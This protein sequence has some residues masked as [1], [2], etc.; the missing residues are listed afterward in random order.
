VQ[1]ALSHSVIKTIFAITTLCLL[2]C[3]SFQSSAATGAVLYGPKTVQVPWSGK[4]ASTA[5]FQAASGSSGFIVIKNGDGRDLSVKECPGRGREKLACELG[6]VELRLLAYLQRPKSIEIQLNGVVIVTSEMLPQTLGALTV[7]VKLSAQNTIQLSAKGFPESN[8]TLT[9]LGQPIHV[10]LPPVASF[11]FSPDHEIAPATVTFTGLSSHDPDGTIQSYNWDFGD[12]T[13]LNGPLAIHLYAAAGVYNVKL[14][15]TDDLGAT[16]STLQPV[17]VL[18]NQPPVSSFTAA[19][20]TSDGALKLLLDGSAS[21]DPDGS[22]ATYT[23]DFG[24]GSTAQG[25]AVQHI[26]AAPGTYSVSLTVLDNKGSSG[27]STQPLAVVDHTAPVITISAPL[28]G[29]IVTSQSLQVS[30]SS[31]KN[32]ASIVVSLGNA[33]SV[34]LQLTGITFS[35]SVQATANGP[36][37][38]TFTATDLAGNTQSVHVPV[39]F[40]YQIIPTLKV[41]MFNAQQ[42][43]APFMTAFST[44]G[45]SATDNAAL[46]FTYD[47]GDGT[48]LKTQSLTQSHTYVNSGSFQVIVKALHPSGGYASQSLM[49]AVTSLSLPVH[50]ETIAPPLGQSMPTSMVDQVSFIYSGSNPIQTGADVTT[51]DPLRIAVLKGAVKDETGSPLPGVQIS[52]GGHTEFGSTLSRDDGQFDLVVNGGGQ[53][54]LNY[55]RSGYFSVSRTIEP[56]LADYLVTAD[57]LMSRP[58]SAVSVVDVTGSGAYQFI[59]SSPVTDSRGTRT[60]RLL[61][62]S[63]TQAKLQAKDGSLSSV[64]QLSVRGTEYTVGDTGPQRMP[65]TLPQTSAYTYA[66]ELSADEAIAAGASHVLFSKPVFLYTDNFLNFP[67]GAGVPLGSLDETRGLWVPETDGVI[68]KV[69]SVTGGQAVLSASKDESQITPAQLSLLAI[70]NEELTAIG[71]NYTAGQSFW[72][73]SLNHFTAVDLN[74]F[75]HSVDGVQTPLNLVINNDNKCAIKGQKTTACI[76]D[77]V[78][79]SLS[80]K[81]AVPGA[82]FDLIYDSARLPGGITGRSVTIPVLNKG[83][84]YGITAS[85]AEISIAGRVLSTDI[86]VGTT[87]VDFIWD[88]KDIYG[89]YVN[90]IVPAV[91]LTSVTFSFDYVVGMTPV[92]RTFA[93]PNSTSS[94][95]IT[96]TGN[97]VNAVFTKTARIWLGH[98]STSIAED[99]NGWMISTHHRFDPSS[100]TVYKGD[101]TTIRSSGFAKLLLPFAGTAQVAGYGGDGGSALLA[102]FSTPTGLALGN[103]NSVYVVDLENNRIRKIAPDGTVSNFAGNGIR[104]SSGDGGTATSASVNAPGRPGFGLDG[105]LYFGE[106][107]GNRIRKVCNGIISTVAGTGVAG[108]SGDGG[109]ATQAQFNQPRGVVIG[110]DGALYIDDSG[111]NRVRKIDAGGIISTFAGNGTAGYS[112]D[113]G[114][115]IAAQLSNP[116]VTSLDSNGNVYVADTG[117][118]AIRRIDTSGIITTVAGTG[119]KGNDGDGLLATVA[120]LDS[121]SCVDVD[122]KGQLFIADG[123]A[124]VVRRVSVDGVISTLSGLGKAGFAA[125]NSYASVTPLNDPRNVLILRNGDLLVSEG[126]NQTVRIITSGYGAGVAG[127]QV[128]APDG[129]EVYQFDLQG[130]HTKTLFGR[131][132]QT[133]VSFTYNGDNVV[134]VT[135]ANGLVTTINRDGS[136]IAKS[137]VTPFGDQ[138]LLVA[139]TNGYLSSFTTATGETTQMQN[140]AR[141]LM[142][143]FTKPK[144]NAT[145][146]TF[147]PGGSIYSAKESNG[148]ISYYFR[149]NTD[150]GGVSSAV[151]A[152]GIYSTVYSAVDYDTLN[153]ASYEGGTFSSS[154]EASGNFTKTKD[155]AGVTTTSTAKTDDRFNGFAT[156]SAKGQSFFRG[157]LR[158]SQNTNTYTGLVS[159][160]PFTFTEKMD[161]VSGDSHFST[162]YSSATKQFKTITPLGRTTIAQIDGQE[163]LIQSRLGAF[164]AE[165]ISYNSIG[166]IAQVTVGDRV[167]RFQYNADGKLLSVTNALG[168]TTQFSIDP[169]GKIRTVASA[170]GDLTKFDYD[171]NSNLNQITPPGKLAHQMIFDLVDL[172]ASYAPPLLGGLPTSTTYTYDA[173]KF[174]L[175]AVRPDGDQIAIVRDKTSGLVTSVTGKTKAASYYYNAAKQISLARTGDGITTS[176]SY[177][178]SLLADSSVSGLVTTQVSYGYTPT[179]LLSSIVVQGQSVPLT[180]NSDEELLT[181]GD[182]TIGRDTVSGVPNLLTLGGT[183]ESIVRSSFGELQSTTTT[184][185]GATFASIAYSRDKLGRIT[186]KNEFFGGPA[187]SLSYGYDK[188]GRLAN[189]VRNGAAITY[190]YDSNGNRLSR[191]A[192]AVTENA[193][194]D[195]QDRLISYNGKSYAYTPYGTLAQTVDQSGGATTYTYDSFGNLISAKLPDGTAVTYLTDVEKHRVAKL[196]NGVAKAT[197]AY[198]NSSQLAAEIDPDG[199]VRNRYIYATSPTSPDYVYHYGVEFKLVKDQLG[200]VRL[201]VNSQ[202]GAITELIDYDE[203]GRVLADTNPGFLAI[204]YV[205]GLFDQDTKLVQ[206][207]ARDYDSET[208]RWLSKDPTLFG[209]GQA[210]L[211]GYVANNPINGI[212][213]SGL[214]DI[215]LF[216]PPS[217]GSQIGNSDGNIP[218]TPGSISVGGH[219]NPFAIGN[220]NGVPLNPQQVGSLINAYPTHQSGQAVTLNSCSVGGSTGDGSAPFAQQLSNILGAPVTAPTGPL[221]IYP[222]GGTQVMGGGQWQTFVPSPVPFR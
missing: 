32:L 88:G 72:R 27:T 116:N 214:S 111:N 37:D 173:D 40:N 200:S 168:E 59:S 193:I 90:Q 102:K 150:K 4:A 131:T 92:Q 209:G 203:F 44:D 98:P 196:V 139:D 208:G 100:Q 81:L 219:G 63:G 57:V 74:F 35:G 53:Y 181:A 166:E 48:T 151:S 155:A 76:I 222:N 85:R 138:Y 157:L 176:Y 56:P 14:T 191:T 202:T 33:A 91:V 129:S 142:Q 96:I 66:L 179:M 78:S 199:K 38:I 186:S 55:V 119:T 47:F 36:T 70:T 97:T 84:V 132:G 24:D 7:P 41:K 211:Y 83:P 141:G 162:L 130:R 54:T 28:S 189:V 29:A 3:V 187:A 50:P 43:T 58:D 171:L 93:S 49:V 89:R 197:Y 25:A 23:W 2:T 212:D 188:N 174:P 60:A 201:V 216:P 215:N 146:Y 101:G 13:T 192:G 1:T 80:E 108:F 11:T 145:A 120:H 8:F 144:G 16:S 170:A 185:G 198:Q 10:N 183:A 67:I 86:A 143:L 19:L 158:G 163:R 99:A 103:D 114:P 110:K 160:D 94:E 64:N 104:G 65:G 165:M 184:F 159:N 30:G 75:F 177:F 107:S 12:G 122:Q 117:S 31:N 9:V 140:D 134:T 39:T 213:P 207:G 182:L 218:A 118:H 128:P 87:S 18:I 175:L 112:G 73:V 79:Q 82:P 113:G 21:K 5:S 164:E 124:H 167:T 137:I 6:N 220:Q 126:G 71:A 52:V 133:A 127:Y 125:S 221:M 51:F 34:P 190:V 42:G 195:A 22:I 121:P 136:G 45:S 26:Y 148:A 46:T 156:Y 178:G 135:D 77:S 123:A 210:N 61:F 204:G 105:C 169:S 172:V 115:A 217:S 205:G 109:V 161:S 180:Y 95:S 68:L 153:L 149:T 62:P 206:F 152:T 106:F 147:K 194:Y 17:T 69:L 15:V 154:V 20:D